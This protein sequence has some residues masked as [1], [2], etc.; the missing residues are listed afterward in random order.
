MENG[1]CSVGVDG[2]RK[3]DANIRQGDDSLVSSVEEG[4]VDY[5]QDKGDILQR[6]DRTH[7]THTEDEALQRGQKEGEKR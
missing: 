7:E 6:E 2:V 4:G 3:E 1:M 5:M